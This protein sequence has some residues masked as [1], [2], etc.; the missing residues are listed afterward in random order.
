MWLLAEERKFIVA[1]TKSKTKSKS[2]TR[3]SS[4]PPKSNGSSGSRTKAGS[5]SNGSRAKGKTNGKA[6]ASGAKAKT[7]GKASRA[8]AKANGKAKTNGGNGIADS[9]KRGAK[10]A[11]VPL[12]AS[13]AALAGVAGAI[14]AS[15]SGKRHKVLGVPM[16]KTNGIKPDAKKIS[17]AVVDAANRAERF[18]QGVSKVANSVRDA[19][20]TA[21]K[22]AKK[23]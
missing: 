19:G 11:K 15:R 23:G 5:G 10:G 7:N 4:S 8:N 12:L 18:G 2:G 20:E 17:G 6:K 1:Q 3:K 13:G 16:P 21:N 9:V 22:V 14:A